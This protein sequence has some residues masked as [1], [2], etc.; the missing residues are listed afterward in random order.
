VGGGGTAS[1]FGPG[2]VLAGTGDVI[3][4]IFSG[5]AFESPADF[6]NTAIKTVNTYENSKKLTD[7]GIAEE[8][9]RILT[10]SLNSIARSGANGFAF[11]QSGTIGTQVTKATQV[12]L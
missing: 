1:L 5:K 7:A 2:G 11:P 10:G 9:K 4:D 8:G 6:I 12:K 3:G